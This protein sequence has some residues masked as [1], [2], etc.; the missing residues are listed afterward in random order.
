MRRLQRSWSAREAPARPSPNTTGE[1]RREGLPCPPT[2]AAVGLGGLALDRPQAASPRRRRG[3]GGG[4]QSAV[5]GDADGVGDD[6]VLPRG[7]Y[8]LTLVNRD[9]PRSGK[10]S[11]P[12]ARKRLLQRPG[13]IDATRLL[14]VPVAVPAVATTARGGHA[15]QHPPSCGSG[16]LSLPQLPAV[17]ARPVRARSLSLLAHVPHWL[18]KTST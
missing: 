14:P 5:V 7:P 2:A 11:P 9:G 8:L 6:G 16:L 13:K 12:R 15:L 18:G 17:A 10:W 3:D 1:G 4:E